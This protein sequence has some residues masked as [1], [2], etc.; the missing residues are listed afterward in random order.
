MFGRL[1]NLRC[2]GQLIVL[3]VLLLFGQLLF[4]HRRFVLCRTILWLFVSA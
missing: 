3:G 4:G 1:R 2:F